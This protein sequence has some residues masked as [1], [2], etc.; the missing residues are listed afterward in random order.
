METPVTYLLHRQAANGAKSGGHAARLLTHWYPM[1]KGFGPPGEA[2]R[3]E[4]DRGSF[5]EWKNVH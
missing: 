5:L 3:S 2:R 1:V 4:A